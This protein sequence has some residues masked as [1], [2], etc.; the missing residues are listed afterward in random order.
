VT[1]ERE[2]RAW[3]LRQEFRSEREIGD[4][5]GVSESGVCRM[6]QR[7][8][9]RALEK[10]QEDVEALKVQQTAQLEFI[11]HEAMAAWQRSKGDSSSAAPGDPK[12]LGEA[13]AALA[14]IR[15][16]WG[17]EAP[18][19]V[20]A[21]TPDGKEPYRLQVQNMTDE[22]LEL[23]ERIAARQCEPVARIGCSG[24]G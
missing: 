20:A 1:R 23:L 4:I 19:K 6:L 18:T 17:A 8:E 21:T 3:E 5:L 10:L 15:R 24:T 14:E 13:R 22:E 7:V 2:R 11:A 12:F 9:R 16:I